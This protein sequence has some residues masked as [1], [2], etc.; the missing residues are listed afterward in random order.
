MSFIKKFGIFIFQFCLIVFGI[1]AICCLPKLF[2][3]ESKQ[4]PTTQGMPATPKF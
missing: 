4:M 3:T 2:L 1:I